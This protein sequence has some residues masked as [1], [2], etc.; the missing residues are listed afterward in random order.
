MNHVDESMTDTLPPI[1][2]FQKKFSSILQKAKSK[3]SDAADKV[4]DQLQNFDAHHGITEKFRETGE[5]IARGASRLDSRFELSERFDLATQRAIAVKESV[6]A[7]TETFAEKSGIDTAIA[8]TKERLNGGVLQPA[9]RLAHDVGLINAFD[10]IGKTFQ[11]TY[12]KTRSLLKP[13]FPPESARE[14]LE[15]TRYELIRLSSTIM[16]TSANETERLASQFSAAVV[17]KVSGLAAA[18]LTLGAVSMLGTAGTGTA[19]ASLS[20]AAA[21]SASLA[22]VGGLLGGGMAT[23]ALVTGGLSIVVGLGAYRLLKSESRPFDLLT[24]EEQRIVQACWM[25]INVIDDYLKAD[26][27]QLNQHDAEQLLANA[28]IPLRHL[29]H[30]ST[31][32]VCDSLDARHAMVYRQHVLVDFDRVVINGFA[33]QINGEEQRTD[34]VAESVIGGVFYALLTRTAVDDSVESQ[35]VLDAL[36]RSDNTLTAA[37]EAQIS[38]YLDDYS[39]EQLKGIANNI[40]GIYHELLYV[41]R[42]NKANTDTYAEVFA[43]TNHPGADIVLRD[44]QTHEVID[45]FQLKATDSSAYIQEHFER[46]DDI[47]VL[48]TDEVAS[49]LPGVES[50]GVTNHEI[51]SRVAEDLGALSDNTLV[52]RVVESTLLMGTAVAGAEF[53]EM[54]RGRVEFPAA[55]ANVARSGGVAGGASLIAAYLFS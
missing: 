52:D 46:Y 13:Y 23:G 24:E 3:V 22:W 45:Q 12:G 37:S 31:E 34:R 26:D 11:E 33:R 21:N 42:Y 16:Q 14:L 47:K 9:T 19:I 44:M 35:L 30:Q 32:T 10:I 41:D 25:L 17:A 29:I 51:S 36:R 53:I 40:K 50:S 48:A 5:T 18:G 55:V 6:I 15:N 8:L 28:L 54:L 4:G 2:R 43:A 7:S 38:E 49:D 39:A 27:T 20:G 1:R